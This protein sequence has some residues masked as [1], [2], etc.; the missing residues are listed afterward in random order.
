M[1]EDEDEESELA[2]HFIRKYESASH[3][4]R[5][6]KAAAAGSA[7]DDGEEEDE[8][9]ESEPAANVICKPLHKV[10]KVQ[11]TKL[12]DS[13]NTPFFLVMQPA[14][15]AVS[16]FDR[17]RRGGGRVQVQASHLH[18]QVQVR[19]HFITQPDSHNTFP[20][21]SN[22]PSR[23]HS[24]RTIPPTPSISHARPRFE[25]SLPLNMNTVLGTNL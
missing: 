17:R 1:E 20:L 10:K 2:S 13:V 11:D 12:L 19:H 24:I 14:A 4:I 22:D 6:Y 9:K 5:K 21:D 23:P 18:P 7:I 16:S 8:E 15:A 3:S 25:R